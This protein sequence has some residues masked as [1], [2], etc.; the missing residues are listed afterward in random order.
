M[1][2]KSEVHRLIPRFCSLIP[3]QFGVSINKFCSDNA[4]ELA[5]SDYFSKQG[6]FHQYSCVET[7]EQNSVVERK[8]QHLLNIARALYF[9]YQVPITFW[10]DCVLTVTHFISRTPTQF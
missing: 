1:K 6:I 9:Q 4:K 10:C 7:P 8:H 5:L 3:T 2:Y